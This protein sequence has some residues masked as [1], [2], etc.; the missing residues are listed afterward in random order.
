MGTHILGGLGDH[1]EGWYLHIHGWMHA[2]NMLDGI[3][4]VNPKMKEVPA[5]MNTGIY[6]Q[7]HT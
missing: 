7:I 1:L 2:L 5:F 4:G 6:V 3:I